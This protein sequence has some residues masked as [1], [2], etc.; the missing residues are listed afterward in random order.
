MNSLKKKLYFIFSSNF[1]LV[2]F[3]LS[4]RLYHL[5]SATRCH[6]QNR[7]QSQ[8]QTFWHIFSLPFCCLPPEEKAM[9]SAELERHKKE[10]E[11]WKRKAER[12]EDQASAL[13]VN[14]QI[15]SRLALYPLD[16]LWQVVALCSRSLLAEL[17]WGQLCFGI[18]LPPHWPA[19]TAG[20]ANGGAEETRWGVW[21]DSSWWESE[22]RV[23][24]RV[25]ARII[26]CSALVLYYN[27]IRNSLYMTS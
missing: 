2:H 22:Q 14:N 12:L 10:K 26:S 6:F 8:R 19:R 27:F 9:Y 24:T 13:Q 3:N 1:T 17:G 11:E 18:G 20:G 21:S 5:S 4:L 15:T 16:S 7:L 25:G 23:W